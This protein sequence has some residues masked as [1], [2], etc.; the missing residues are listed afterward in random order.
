MPYKREASKTGENYDLPR[1]PRDIIYD[2]IIGDLMEAVEL[3]P[4][5]NEVP[6][7]ER[8]TKGAVKGILARIA[9]HAAGKSLRW[10]LSTGDISSMK[11]AT[12]EDESRIRELYTIARDQTKQVM[13]KG[14]HQL[15]PSFENVWKNIC[16]Y[17]MDSEYYENIFE[18]GFYSRLEVRQEAGSYGEYNGP[19]SASE[20]K[21]GK[22]DAGMWAMPGFVISFDPDD[23]RRATSVWNMRFMNTTPE[24]KKNKGQPTE[25][26]SMTPAKW[27][28][29]WAPEYIAAYTNF[30]YPMLRYSD[31]LL[32]FAEADSWLAGRATEDA[33]DALKQVRKRAFSTK[34][35]EIEAEVYPSDFE[36]FLEVIIQE[37]AFELA[38]EG[39]RKTDLIRWGK[40][41]EK[42]AETKAEN[43][44]LIDCYIA[45]DANT[46]LN[47]YNGRVERL[48]GVEFPRFTYNRDS[49]G[50]YVEVVYS[51]PETNSADWNRTNWLNSDFADGLGQYA[52]GFVE[53]RT[54]L[55]PIPSKKINVSPAIYQL[56]GYIKTSG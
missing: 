35:D 3:V 51:R 56:P 15:N 5:A 18:L 33:I 31:I 1:T 54:E 25:F 38:F 7:N 27:R 22:A 50:E 12:R 23:T 52:I 30:N 19:R 14:I 48:R 41:A 13:E 9:L 46:P 39:F 24:Y 20:S 49:D 28:K 21:F 16:N 11:M 17:R 37:R 2:D 29:Q 26:Y 32:M 55:N 47:P 45:G 34:T 4:W 36:G 40:L 43:Q 44:A 6:Q 53:N 10:D 8:L 42:I